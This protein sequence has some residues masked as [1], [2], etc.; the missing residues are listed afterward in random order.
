MPV[1]PDILKV[2]TTAKSRLFHVEEIDLRFSNGVER[3]YERL[4]SR[5]LGAVMIAAIDEQQN[6][7]LIQEYAVG[8]EDYLLTLPKGLIDPGEDALQAANRELKEEA[9][10]GAERLEIIKEMTSAPNYMGHKITVV[11]AQGLYPCRLPGDEPEEMP[12]THWP[13]SQLEELFSRDD[14]SEG[15]AIAALYM[16]RDQLRNAQA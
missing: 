15:R 1:K 16:V 2:T 10:F 9:G 13:L 4:A 7:L 5:G 12:V 6:V 11:L 8:L 3:T 14:F